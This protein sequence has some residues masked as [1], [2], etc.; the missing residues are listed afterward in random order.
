MHYRPKT[1][2]T[3]GSTITLTADMFGVDLGNGTYGETDRTE[4]VHVHAAR[5]A[6]HM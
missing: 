2:W 3:A 4:T 1:Y 5:V 6:G